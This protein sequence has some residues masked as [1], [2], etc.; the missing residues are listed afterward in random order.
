M[1]KDI[2]FLIYINSTMTVFNQIFR[3]TKPFMSYFLLF[4][5]VSFLFFCAPPLK[6]VS[7]NWGLKMKRPV[8]L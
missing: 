2:Y 1:H 4:S 5:V 6:A 3:P 8:G 7:V